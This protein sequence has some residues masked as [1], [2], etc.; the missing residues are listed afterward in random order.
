[1]FDRIG[2]YESLCKRGSNYK[3]IPFLNQSD[4]NLSSFLNGDPVRYN[5]PALRIHRDELLKRVRD[6][7]I[8]MHL[9]KK[10][11]GVVEDRIESGTVKF[12]DRETATATFVVGTDGLHSQVRLFVAPDTGEPSYSRK[13][14]FGV[15]AMEDEL[16][17]LAKNRDLPLPFMMF[18]RNGSFSI[19]PTSF[20]IKE[21]NY[22]TSQ[23][24]GDRGTKRWANLISNKEELKSKLA[25]RFVRDSQWPE[26]VKKLCEDVSLIFEIYFH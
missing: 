12:E 16:E 6:A 7:G 15:I 10:C 25:E 18:G 23:E 1:V 11:A 13:V 22:F 5:F 19:M 4:T 8:Q 14:G 2:I 21:I 9:G 20:D 24:S 17:S 3:E 26:L